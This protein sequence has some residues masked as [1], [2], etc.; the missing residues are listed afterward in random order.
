MAQGLRIQLCHCS[1]SDC[2]C[3]AGSIPGGGMWT[4]YGLGKKK[5][6]K[7]KKNPK[8]SENLG[9]HPDPLSLPLPHIQHQQKLRKFQWHFEGT[10]C[11]ILEFHT[12]LSCLLGHVGGGGRGRREYYQIM[13]T[14]KRSCSQML[15]CPTVF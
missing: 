14:Q 12:K 7:K 9:N 13:R 6:K 11:A 2:C 15:H 4:Y 10:F 5:K 8:Q 3:G 1:D